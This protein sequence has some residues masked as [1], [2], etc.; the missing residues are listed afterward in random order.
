MAE[1]VRNLSIITLR[2]PSWRN[3]I[4]QTTEALTFAKLEE[5][6]RDHLI[7]LIASAC[8]FF[9]PAAVFL[10]ITIRK[11]PPLP[12]LDYVSTTNI[13]LA[14]TFFLAFTLFLATTPCLKQ[15][16]CLQPPSCVQQPFPLHSLS[17]L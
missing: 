9:S 6:R 7:H 15:H 11:S 4:L 5:C 10:S 2:F 13:R 8:S 3:K 1:M 12:S 17:S 16:S 14:T